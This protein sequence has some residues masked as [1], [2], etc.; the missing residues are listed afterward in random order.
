MGVV[1]EGNKY[2][3]LYDRV[4]QDRLIDNGVFKEKY[5]A[6]WIEKKKMRKR[7]RNDTVP[8]GYKGRS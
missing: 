4:K 5:M 1:E 2:V 7:R 8:N 3:E 6:H